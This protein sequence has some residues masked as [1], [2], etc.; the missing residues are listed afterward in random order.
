MLPGH[1]RD[2]REQYGASGIAQPRLVRMQ[3]RQ[4]RGV[5]INDAVG[6]E[7]TA[8]LPELLFIFRLK[9]QLPEVRVGDRPAELM[10]I[11]SPVECPLDVAA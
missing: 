10:V 9:A 8:F 1:G 11:F 5:K 3:V 2:L 7:P 6:D 4:N